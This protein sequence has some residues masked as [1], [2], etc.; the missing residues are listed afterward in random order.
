MC[1][2][3]FTR[4][5]LYSVSFMRDSDSHFVAI[6]SFKYRWSSPYCLMEIGFSSL[7][8]EYVNSTREGWFERTTIFSLII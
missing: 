1:R 5:F 2:T 4:Y 3:G 7:L 8:A 6:L